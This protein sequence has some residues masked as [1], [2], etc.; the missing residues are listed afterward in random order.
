MT[1]ERRAELEVL[2][3][4]E[5]YP[6]PDRHELG[7]ILEGLTKS[8]AA[9]DLVMQYLEE[10]L[11]DAWAPLKPKSEDSEDAD[12]SEVSH[13]GKATPKRGRPRHHKPM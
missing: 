10:D 4:D 12:E 11:G 6:E 1:E 5:I 3:Q 9:R 7:H 2:I 8:K 13:E